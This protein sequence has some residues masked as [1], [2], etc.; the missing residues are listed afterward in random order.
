[1]VAYGPIQNGTLGPPAKGQRT[2]RQTGTVSA[3]LGGIFGGVPDFG[4][5]PEGTF[6]TYRRMRANPTIA[7]ARAVANA[8]IKAANWSYKVD[9]SRPTA[10]N[11][12]GMLKLIQDTLAPLRAALVK[13]LLFARDY[14]FQGFEKVVEAR[15][16]AWVYSD[17]KPLLPDLTLPLVG[18]RSGRVMG[19]RNGS[20]DLTNPLEYLLWT[21]NGEGG[22]PYGEPD[23]ERCRDAWHMETQ[24]Y[25]RMGQYVTKVAGVIPMVQYPMGES[26]DESGQMVDNQVLASKVLT[27]LSSGAGVTMPATV[28][29]WAQDLIRAGVPV[30]DLMAWQ[31]KF[32]EAGQQH[33]ADFDVILRKFDALM[34]RGW[35]VPERAITEGA[36]GTKAESETQADLVLVIAQEIMDDIIA[37]VNRCVVDPLLVVNFGPDAAG[38]VQ[39]EAEPIVD[40]ARALVRELVKT[41]L[42]NPVNLDIALAT[43]DF[44]AML[45]QSGLP[46]IAAT[47]DPARVRALPAPAGSGTLAASM[48]RE[49]EGVLGALRAVTGRERDAA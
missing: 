4:R 16:G 21:Y 40:E 47:V 41:V 15:G 45:D 1:M 11:A 17:F 30:Q 27:N 24:T 48:R 25:R 5:P 18:A 10:A 22:D 31:I 37:L 35:L 46:K 12:E 32:I 2:K 43:L 19:L 36:H 29:E 39:V 28:H 26:Q 14:G 49:Y 42:T 7:L 13:N 44:D 33:G 9:E 34:V 6:S 3:F 20:A 8:P 23:M 38:A